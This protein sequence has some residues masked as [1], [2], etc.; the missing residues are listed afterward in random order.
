MQSTQYNV[1]MYHQKKGRVDQSKQSNASIYHKEIGKVVQSKQSNVNKLCIIRKIK[2]GSQIQP[3]IIR[4]ENKQCNAKQS[5]V[6]VTSED[7][8][9]SVAKI[10][11]CIIRRKKRQCNAKQSNVNVTSE[12]RRSSVAKIVKCIIRRKKKQCNA[13]QSDVNVLSEERSSE[14]TS[15]LGLTPVMI[16]EE[17]YRMLLDSIDFSRDKMKYSKQTIYYLIFKCF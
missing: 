11:K 6:N 10:V 16:W 13:K 15:D 14:A 2:L 7:R 4:R 5:N 3:C 12:D 1:T 8:R 17:G 9:S